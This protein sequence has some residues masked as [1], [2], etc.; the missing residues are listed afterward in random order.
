MK[1]HAH[2]LW[3]IVP[4]GLLA[5]AWWWYAQNDYDFQVA[6]MPW[7]LP[8][9]AT[10]PVNTD[11]PAASQTPDTTSQGTAGQPAVTPNAGAT[12]SH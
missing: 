10:V 8:T 6:F 12:H 5:L 3:L 1:K 9:A 2:W 7:T 4:G 11:A